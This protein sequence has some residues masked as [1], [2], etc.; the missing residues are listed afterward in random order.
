LFQTISHKDKVMEMNRKEDIGNNEEHPFPANVTVN[1]DYLFGLA[2]GDKGFV[3]KMIEI[4]VKLIPENLLSI[5][6][7]LTDNDYATLKGVAHR[8]KSTV[9]VA[10]LDHLMPFFTR[11]EWESVNNKI[12]DET[13]N[14]F[15]NVKQELLQSC[16][17][18]QKYLSENF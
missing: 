7:A 4:Y 12:E 13:N 18:L 2:H 9:S 5:E 16:I 6:K 17:V 15:I 1:F 8:T 11:L 10:G 14:D 3:K